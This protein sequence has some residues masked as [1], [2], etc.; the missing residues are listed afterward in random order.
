MEEIKECKKFFGTLESAANDL[1]KALC[2][3]QKKYG[4]DE[5]EAMNVAQLFFAKE[6]IK[7]NE[8]CGK[9]FIAGITEDFIFKMKLFLFRLLP[10]GEDSTG[11]FETR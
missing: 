3:I 5:D 4:L 9:G 7:E 2:R 10:E 1:E 8:S 11:L 6:I